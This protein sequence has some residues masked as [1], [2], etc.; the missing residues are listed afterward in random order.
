MFF[1]SPFFP[2]PNTYEVRMKN[3]REHVRDWAKG[4]IQAV[5]VPPPSSWYQHIKLIE[6]ADALLHDII[7]QMPNLALSRHIV[8]NYISMAVESFER[9]SF[10]P[11]EAVAIKPGIL[12]HCSARC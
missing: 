3:E 11:S 5:R 7:S 4:E 8:R 2:A 10:M 1:P 12:A 9:K 6:A